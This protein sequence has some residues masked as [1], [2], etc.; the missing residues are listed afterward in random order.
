MAQEQQHRDHRQTGQTQIDLGITQ[1][2]PPTLTPRF[3]REGL[4]RQGKA[5]KQE[6]KQFPRQARQP[7][8]KTTDGG[9]P[10]GRDDRH[11]VADGDQAFL[12]RQDQQQP[13]RTGDPAINRQ[14]LPRKPQQQFTRIGR[15]HRQGVVFRALADGLAADHLKP[16]KVQRRK[17]C[18]RRHPDEKAP[19][20]T[21]KRAP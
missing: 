5:Q 2:T 12:A 9:N 3:G 17:D 20:P 1:Q 13:Q 18:K 15:A 8:L 10:A 21:D 16:A 7:V 14:E 11:G 4:A 6:H 19:H